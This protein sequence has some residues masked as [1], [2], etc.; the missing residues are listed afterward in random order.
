MP[1]IEE[2]IQIAAPPTTVFKLC[3]DLA[4]WPEWDERVVGV[5]LLSPRPVRRGTLVS[6]DAGRS[7]QFRFSWDA[8]YVDFQFPQD[9]T[10]RVVDAAPSSPFKTG[11]EKWRCTAAS[12]G[13]RF[14]LTWDYQP[15]NVLSRIL[16]AL[17][18][19]V[20]TRR[21]IQRSLANLKTLA[22]AG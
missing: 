5:E 21:A 11:T 18:G 13:T 4:R 1:R 2:S 10:L 15:R 12:D 8:E 22:E 3:H 6:V 7:G 19:R 20:A 17:G 14:T 9:L 16:D